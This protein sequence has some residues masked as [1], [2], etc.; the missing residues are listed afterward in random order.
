M[1]YIITIIFKLRRTLRICSSEFIDLF[2]DSLCTSYIY[3]YISIE[4]RSYQRPKVM[5]FTFL[6]KKELGRTLLYPS[7]SLT[8]QYRF[9]AYKCLIK[10]RCLKKR[11]DYKL[12]LLSS[13]FGMFLFSSFIVSTTYICFQCSCFVHPYPNYVVKPPS[14]SN[15]KIVSFYICILTI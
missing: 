11:L 6:S 3:F 5:P 8:Y 1:F 9:F 4:Y 15:N 10:L 12:C 13:D 2:N 14:V 7:Q